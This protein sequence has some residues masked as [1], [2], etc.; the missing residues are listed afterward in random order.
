MSDNE[1]SMEKVNSALASTSNIS[2]VSIKPPPFWKP[3]P[4]ICFLQ[5]EAQFR[6]AS[7]K[8]D[9]TK[10]D[11]VVSSI[12]TGILS[13]VSDILTYPPKDAKYTTLSRNVSF[14]F[15]RKLKL[16]TQKLLTDVE[17][18]DKKVKNL[19]SYYVK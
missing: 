6:N 11:Y 4:K 3:E 15:S 1:S 10:F 5:L 9:Q 2:R 18:G 13:Q 8:E 17:L 16:K 19:L 14:L 12:E 7:I